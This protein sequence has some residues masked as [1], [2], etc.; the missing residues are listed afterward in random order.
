[1]PRSRGSLNK[2]LALAPELNFTTE[3]R[4]GLL[5]NLIVDKIVDEALI[6]Q[7]PINKFLQEYHARST[8]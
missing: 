1:M 2:A 3:E 4:L 5:A 8:S 7:L 6:E